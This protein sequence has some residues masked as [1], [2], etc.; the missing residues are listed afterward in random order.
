MKTVVFLL[1]A[2]LLGSLSPGYFL[3]KLKARKDIREIGSGSTGA[4]NVLRYQGWKLAI[5][6]MLFDLFKGFLPVYLANLLFIDKRMSLLGL[7]A[8]VAGHCFPFYLKFRGGKG[9]AT[10]IGGFLFLA[11]GPMLVCLT[12]I[13]IMLLIFRYVS[14]AT[15]TGLFLFP[16]LAFLFGRDKFILLGGLLIFI[17]IAWRHKENIK[18]LLQGQE[19]KFGE[20]INA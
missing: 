7:L 4:T 11:P 12:I 3:V 13:L 8:A 15:L 9:V 17:I 14:L 2:Y 6:V 18:R 10:S 16:F 5:P 19:R 20:K 1:G